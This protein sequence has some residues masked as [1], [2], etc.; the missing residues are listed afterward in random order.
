MKSIFTKTI[1]L[2]TASCALILAIATITNLNAVFQA[3]AVEDS[4]AEVS[5]DEPT[6]TSPAN[7]N[8]ANNTTAA[9]SNNTDNVTNINST[10]TADASAADTNAAADDSKALQ[11]TIEQIVN[12][13]N[14]QDY[15][16]VFDLVE[17]AE[18]LDK[19]DRAAE[20]RLKGELLSA[21]AKIGGGANLASDNSGSLQTKTLAEILKD[22]SL[23]ANY[24]E[25][26]ELANLVKAAQ[27]IIASDKTSNAQIS[28]I[29]QTTTN[30]AKNVNIPVKNSTKRPTSPN[31]SAQ[32]RADSSSDKIVSALDANT[33]YDVNRPIFSHTE[34]T[35]SEDDTER[36]NALAN[37]LAHTTTTC[38]AFG[39]L[40]IGT[41]SAKRQ[42]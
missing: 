18:T 3:E 41:I 23:I 25:Y 11:D 27:T 20:N 4:S 36:G 5:T 7:S 13:Q 29:L 28:Q 42:K 8:S 33:R 38:V 34:T 14:F 32:N 24:Q 16:R 30:A 31:D 17:Q 21:L 26:Y 2:T 35:H 39:T 40:I 19:N 37:A 15:S 12:D 22:T 9:D 1:L 6:S 10:N